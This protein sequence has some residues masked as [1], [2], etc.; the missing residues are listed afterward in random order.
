M[1]GLF[2]KFPWIRY[3]RIWHP[4]AFSDISYLYRTPSQGNVYTLHTLGLRVP[5][6]PGTRLPLE[7]GMTYPFAKTRLDSNINYSYRAWAYRG[8]RSYEGK[9]KAEISCATRRDSLPACRAARSKK[10]APRM[11][12]ESCEA[13]RLKVNFEHRNVSINFN[14]VASAPG[15]GKFH[16]CDTFWILM[17][18][19]VA[20]PKKTIV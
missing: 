10:T 1:G 13:Y 4:V 20:W 19:G 15:V 6:L 2:I 8:R 17:A 11:Y 7:I 18:S 14:F 3:M 16:W 12:E 9:K 5:G